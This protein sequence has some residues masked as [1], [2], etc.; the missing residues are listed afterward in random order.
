MQNVVPHFSKRPG[1][2]RW[3]GPNRI[4]VDTEAVLTELGYTAEGIRGMEKRGVVK[5]ADAPAP[6]AAE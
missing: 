6:E 3:I 2:I 1:R 5:L 4:G